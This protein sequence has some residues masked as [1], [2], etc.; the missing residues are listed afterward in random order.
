LDFEDWKIRK[1]STFLS[2]K[3]LKSLPE[4]L[5]E[6]EI[7]RDFLK[8][9]FLSETH[10]TWSEVKT[11]LFLALLHNAIESKWIF[12]TDP[13]K[14][15]DIW[16]AKS[17]ISL[18]RFLHTHAT[19]LIL[20]SNKKYQQME[21]VDRYSSYGPSKSRKS[22]FLPLLYTLNWQ[23]ALSKKCIIRPRRELHT[24][25]CGKIYLKIFPTFQKHP[26]PCATC[27][28]PVNAIFRGLLLRHL[29]VLC[30]AKFSFCSAITCL[31]MKFDARDLLL[32]YVETHPHNFVVFWH[33]NSCNELLPNW[34]AHYLMR[35]CLVI[36]GVAKILTVFLQIS[37]QY[38]QT[39]TGHTVSLWILCKFDN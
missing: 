1:K 2:Q 12:W 28:K 16:S 25:N 3:F 19:N 29:R 15:W 4:K 26:Y 34:D 21:I 36:K 33:H 9:L 7:L 11:N 27:K 20:C 10:E 35:C 31:R 38:H 13:I 6:I 37:C 8:L 17:D 39:S 30:V 18:G 23:C 32:L 24:K 22:A 14:R 5:H